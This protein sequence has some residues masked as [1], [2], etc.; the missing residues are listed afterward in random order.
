MVK[1]LRIRN[2]AHAKT[3]MRTSKAQAAVEFV[4]FVGVAIVL[5]MLF[6]GVSIY[7]LN[8]SYQREIVQ[9][10]E[11]LS[12]LI[13]NEINLAAVVENGYSRDV[14]LPAQIKGK[15]YLI[16][17]GEASTSE[18]REVVI[19]FEGVEVVEQLAV[20]IPSGVQFTLAEAKTGVRIRKSAD[21]VTVTKLA[22][23]GF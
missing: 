3:M 4:T 23:G 15:D 20:D 14:D 13:K 6:L 12:R 2:A 17:V 18:K 21:V 10:A 5:L 7:Y 1:L 8:L 19:N 16:M 22:V 11:D 9:S